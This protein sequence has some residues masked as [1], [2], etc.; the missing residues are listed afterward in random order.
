M[1]V[2]HSV[3]LVTRLATAKHRTHMYSLGPTMQ[4]SLAEQNGTQTEF[5]ILIRTAGLVLT[6][7]NIGTN[8]TPQFHEQAMDILTLLVLGI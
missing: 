4:I 6:E 5:F 7:C 3:T 1:S 2:Q 8:C